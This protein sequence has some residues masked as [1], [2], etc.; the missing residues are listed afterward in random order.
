MMTSLSQAQVIKES[1]Y[2]VNSPS[3]RVSYIL[4]TIHA[5]VSLEEFR[6]DIR[7]LVSKSQSVLT[8]VSLTADEIN[9]Y[10]R[11]PFAVIEKHSPFSGSD[12]DSETKTKL[13]GIGFPAS[14]VEKLSD[15]D[16]GVL[17]L[18]SETRSSVLPMDYVVLKIARDKNIPIIALDTMELRAKARELNNN[19]E[20]TCSLKALFEKY[21]G[22]QIVDAILKQTKD[23][24]LDYRNGGIPDESVLNSPIVAY[25]NQVWMSS[26][27]PEVEKGQAFIAVGQA[28]L[29]GKKGILTM[30]TEKGYNVKTL[31]NP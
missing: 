25:R 20:G 2:Q 29:Y 14:F 16:C 11:R 8:E 22:Q 26:I 27:L 3:G 24:A 17:G 28:H 19:S 31:T 12:L 13:M 6:S 1:L 18:I 5:E 21:T 7:R 23:S 4:G 30:L 10:S 9:L 15:K